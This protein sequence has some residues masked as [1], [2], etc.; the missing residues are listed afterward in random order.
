MGR[1]KLIH[2]MC[3]LMVVVASPA[4]NGPTGVRPVTKIDT[5]PI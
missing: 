2:K 3:E 1:P 4:V 5:D